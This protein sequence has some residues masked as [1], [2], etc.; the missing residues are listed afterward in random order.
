M[1]VFKSQTNKQKLQNYIDEFVKSLKYAKQLRPNV[2]WGFY[3]LPYLS[4]WDKATSTNAKKAFNLADIYRQS[5]FIAPSLY[6]FYPD[7]KH[8]TNNNSYLK[9]NLELALKIGKQYHKP[10][11]P[12]IWHRVHPA[13]KSTGGGLL[14][15]AY[16][17]ETVREI[18]NASYQGHKAT[19]IFWWH[20]ESYSFRNQSKDKAVSLEYKSVSDEQ[21]YQYDMFE[22]YYNG[23]KEYLK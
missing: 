2:K 1:D 20:S 13:N 22:K 19:G 21:T 23:I 10:V 15:M 9:N 6:S 5:D 12:F 16:F 17:K 3:H 14:P 11:M 7:S 8:T 18:A 4:Y